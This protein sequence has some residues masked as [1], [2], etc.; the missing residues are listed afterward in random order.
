MKLA[1]N[2]TSATKKTGY[3]EKPIH[4]PAAPTID[5]NVRDATAAHLLHK[6]RSASTAF[7]RMVNVKMSAGKSAPIF[8]QNAG[9]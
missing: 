2:A 5:H 4:R 8:V 6:R 9:L 3:P 1:S 7:R